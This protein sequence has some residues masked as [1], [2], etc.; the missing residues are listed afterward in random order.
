MLRPDTVII[1]V[2]HTAES[3]YMAER[4]TYR[5]AV[6]DDRT[7]PLYAGGRGGGR[8]GRWACRAHTGSVHRYLAYGALGVL[9]V[10]GREERDVLIWAG[11]AQI[12]GV[13]GCAAGH[14]RTRQQAGHAGRPAMPAAAT[15]CDLLKQLLAQQI[16]PAGTTIVFA[17][18]PVIVAGTTLDR[19]DRTSGGRVKFLTP[20]PTCLPCR[21]A[22][23]GHRR[24]DPGR[25]HTGTL[26]AAW[27]PAA[28]SPIA[29]SG[30]TN[31]PAGGKLRRPSSPDRP[32]RCAGGEY[33]RPPWAAWC[34][35]G[36]TGPSWRW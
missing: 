26:S 19:R 2:T 18:A 32:T 4:I 31:D 14:A 33:D 35:Y 21:A 9:I 28:R 1:E 6:A 10:G 36:R 24:T 15:V 11:A 7:A 5:T 8:H 27:A 3:R 17:A 30:R 22:I 23:P 12:G 29:A 20:A 34:R 16:T 13:A 25:H